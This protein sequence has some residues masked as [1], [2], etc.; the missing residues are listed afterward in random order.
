M[1][2]S[3]YL[4]LLPALVLLVGA[5]VLGAAEEPAPNAA[6]TGALSLKECLQ[7]ALRNQTDVIVARNNVAVARSRVDQARASYLPQVSIQN[8]AFKIGS[9]SVLQKISTGTAFDIS[10][11]IFDGG[12]REARVSNTRYGVT[13]STARLS[14]TTQTTVYSVTQAYYEALRARHLADVAETNVKYTE[15]LRDQVKTRAELGDAAKVDVLPVEA[16]LANAKVNL[17]AARN[18]QR[19]ALLR[20]QNA[21]GLAPRAGFDISDVEAAPDPVVLA[22]EKYQ[23]EAVSLR[24]D[25]LESKAGVGA[26]RATLR[27]ARI[28]LYPRP[29]ISGQYQRQI[30]GGFT[31]SGTQI[32]GGFAFDLFSG[33]ANRAA[34]REAEALRAN[35]VQQEQQVLNDIQ[36]QVE[37]AYLNLTSSKDRLAASQISLDAA[38]ENYEVQ[39]ERYNQGVGITLDLLNA[40][41]QLVN[42]QASLV[43]AR[44]DYYIATAQLAY[45]VGQDGGFDAS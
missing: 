8:N 15:G 25:V 3:L 23:T 12:L 11:S 2:M 29:I 24:P 27:G 30:T 13:Q 19:T 38:E 28:N 41:V 26:A 21:M 32:V 6:Q 17:L 9:D 31:T 14:R 45:A 4:F 39:K 40:E 42:A 10:Q 22:L 16:Q 36:V 1:R 5:G 43:Q 35:A 7:L 44:Y 33:G 18:N 20:L 37:T 34:Y